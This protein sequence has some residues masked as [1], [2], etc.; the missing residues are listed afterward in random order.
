MNAKDR[1]MM[2]RA[3][4]Q[5]L[6]NR[7]EPSP[8]VHVA[9]SFSRKIQIVQFEPIDFFCSLSLECYAEDAG[10]KS[11]QAIEWCKNEVQRDIKAYKASLAEPIPTSK[12]P[13]AQ[14]NAREFERRNGP[15]PL[16]RKQ[17]M[18]DDAERD[19]PWGLDQESR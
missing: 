18:L 8:L 6:S 12:Q 10:E 4:E 9:R 19:K 2:R 15:T 7:P 5:R 11:Q 1:R 13:A 3:R 14:A 16:Q 17:A